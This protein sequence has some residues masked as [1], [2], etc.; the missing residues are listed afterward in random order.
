[1]PGMPGSLGRCSGPLPITRNR[2]DIRSPRLVVMVQR[3]RVVVPCD[4]GDLGGEAARART[5]RSAGRCGGSAPGS[6]GRGRTSRWGRRRSPPAAGG[7]RRTRRRTVLPGYLFQY[8]VPPKSPP[9]SM[10]RKSSMPASAE[11]GAG[12]QA[13][14]SAADDGDGDV[15][16]QRGAVDRLGVGIVAGSRRTARPP[17]RTGRSP[18]CRIRLS[19]STRY[20]S[21]SA[22]GS[23]SGVDVPSCR[24]CSRLGGPAAVRICIGLSSPRRRSVVPRGATRERS[25]PSATPGRPV[26]PRSWPWP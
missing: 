6:P 19:R 2:A 23:K 24:R 9:F 21:R 12:D 3:R 15:V 26:A 17:R 7:R 5:G 8:Q 20:F 22:S 13:G 25:C 1:M 16:D 18:S 4:G 14:E 11:P 10:M